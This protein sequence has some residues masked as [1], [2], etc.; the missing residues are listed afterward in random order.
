MFVMKQILTCFRL[1]SS[2]PESTEAMFDAVVT[3]DEEKLTRQLK[4]KNH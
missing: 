3:C 1:Y 2:N 4:G